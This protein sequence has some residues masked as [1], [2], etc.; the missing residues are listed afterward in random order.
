MHRRDFLKGTAATGLLVACG[1]SSGTARPPVVTGTAPAKPQPPAVTFSDPELEKLANAALQAARDAG[2]T[3]ADIRI[4]DYRWQSIGT[5]EDRV[6]SVN[7][8]EDRG[9]GVR[10]I[11]NGTWGF[12]ASARVTVEEAVRVARRAVALAKG[13]SV[14]QKEPVKLAPVEAYRAIWNTPIK[15]DPFEVSLADKIGLLL[16]INAEALKV[17][18]V[19]FCSSRMAFVREHKF[20][21]ST[22]GSYIE[23]TLHRCNPSFTVTSVDRKRGSFQTRSSLSDPQGKGYEYVTDYPWL[24]DVRQAGEDAVAKHTAKSVEPGKRD[25]ILHP[26]NLWLT[27]HES[28]GHPTELD[29]ALGM[30]AN[31]AGTSFLTPDKLG[32]FQ[33]GS[34][35]VNFHGEKTRKGSLAT[36]GYDDDGVKTTEWPLVKDGV[37]VDYQTT[38]DQ[39]HLIGRERSHGTSYAQSW[40]D[41]AFQRMPNINLLPGPEPLTLDQLIAGTEDAILIKGRASYSIDH[42]RYNFQFSG[43]TFHEVKNGKIVGM[44]ND[45]AYQSRTPDFWNACDAICSAEEYYVGGSF[46]DGKGEPGQVNAVSH[47]CAPAR[48]R[49]INILNTKRSV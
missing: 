23:Q 6:Q 37:F 32:S 11:A 5:R 39:A 27:I 8:S 26:T 10:V 3:Y 18:G 13:N 46:Y 43:Q 48:F 4:A 29:R 16:S 35:I 34:K 47:G 2:A 33:L 49:Q 41:V 44:L 38:R 45:V 17:A 20:F 42:Q 7:D 21:A 28:I 40:K 31:Y 24:D 36:C 25:L 15:R 1:G 9:F 30:E 19:S 12:A 14:L 22:E